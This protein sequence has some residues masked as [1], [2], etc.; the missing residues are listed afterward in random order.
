ID[1]TVDT[2]RLASYS[3]GLAANG[4]A[5]FS[6]GELREETSSVRDG[7]LRIDNMPRQIHVELCFGKGGC[8][9]A[10]IYRQCTAPETV[11]LFAVR[12]PARIAD[13]GDWLWVKGR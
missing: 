9:S 6:G 11:L 7:T 2:S 10:L 5:S 8:A 4:H 13:G 3:V 1:R 12:N